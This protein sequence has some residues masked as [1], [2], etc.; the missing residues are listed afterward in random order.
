MATDFWANYRKWN[1]LISERYLR[2]EFANRPVYLDVDDTDLSKIREAQGWEPGDDQADFVA[3]VANTLKTSLR[4]HGDLLEI[5]MLRAKR[6]QGMAAEE[7]PPFVAVL[8][9]FSY[10][11]FRM[12]TTEEAASHNYYTPL[13]EMIFGEDWTEEQR[14]SVHK[15]YV[16]SGPTIWREFARWLEYT[17]HGSHGNP[18][19]ES[20]DRR[21]NIKYPLS[22]AILR[23]S[24]RE[25]LKDCFAYARLRPGERLSGPDMEQVLARW[26]P[27][28]SLSSITKK[29]WAKGGQHRA[30]MAQIAVEE[31]ITWDGMS[32][33][34]TS[35]GR[36]TGNLI[37]L[38]NKVETPYPSIDCSFG[39][40]GRDWSRIERFE[41][42]EGS[43]K[44]YQESIAQPIDELTLQRTEPGL[45]E[46]MQDLSIADLFGSLIRL[47]N[48][49]TGDLIRWIPRKFMVLEYDDELRKWVDTSSTTIDKAMM[50][51]T[52]QSREEKLCSILAPSVSRAPRRWDRGN[53][54]GLPAGWVLLSDVWLGS[55]IRINDKEFIALNS[56]TMSARI[57]LNG[58]LKIPGEKIWL[59]SRLPSV[60]LA[61]H[62]GI[63]QTS[64]SKAVAGAFELRLE[65]SSPSGDFSTVTLDP[66]GDPES[67]SFK[68]TDLELPNGHYR[69]TIKHQPEGGARKDLASAHIGVCSADL[70]RSERF[71]AQ[72]AQVKSEDAWYPTQDLVTR[73]GTELGNSPI[74]DPGTLSLPP[75]DLQ[76][77]STDREEDYLPS[78]GTEQL[79]ATQDCAHYTV[80]PPKE[81][82][83]NQWVYGNCKYCGAPV[84][85]APFRWGS[86]EGDTTLGS[87]K[88][89]KLELIRPV[90]SDFPTAT[91]SSADV[92][93]D[94]LLEACCY[95][96][97]GTS[98]EFLNL[99]GQSSE[100]T[101]FAPEA[102]R[103][104]YSLGH[105]ELWSDGPEEP[106]RWRVTP[107]S[108]VV[109][110]QE[111][112]YLT[113]YRSDN[114][115]R[116]VEAQVR[117]F[118]GSLLISEQP[119]GPA[120]ISIEGLD[121]KELDLITSRLPEALGEAVKLKLAPHLSPEISI[122]D[123]AA[124]IELLP[125]SSPPNTSH[126]F[127]SANL[128]WKEAID[129][130]Q[131]GLYRLPTRPVQHRINL[132]GRWRVTPYQLGKH[133]AGQINGVSL[134][135]YDVESET[136]S[137]SK[138][139]Q[140]P[141]PYDKIATMCTGRLPKFDLGSKSYRYEGVPPWTASSIW[142]GLYG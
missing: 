99:Y 110:A 52:H 41:V 107:P 61:A 14:A 53:M 134:M 108:I 115:I 83:T 122:P 1:E 49:D 34:A 56:K 70:P 106:R 78:H 45:W 111:K 114:F 57:D 141:C 109:S 74:N 48:K 97:T 38:L 35:D 32:E 98:A 67:V 80:L 47:E 64:D 17:M 89:A 72:D 123:R 28:S 12:T 102:I 117:T 62:A 33:D 100:G 5:H 76:G 119:D 26:V 93:Y 42:V 121:L 131:P 104:L 66:M 128:T 50:I 58:G 94:A 51:L 10:A 19:A 96:T 23:T 85:G 24:D 116:E 120:F 84:G 73:N 129:P 63:E 124:L 139:S 59:R 13:T 69:L 3:V 20:L 7:P 75:T 36:R 55:A 54:R 22:Q 137:C 31:L 112:A 82:G 43:A 81:K 105:L 25:N 133:L 140:L 16:K 101:G 138:G 15:G 68:L 87:D 127:D 103:N 136:I 29:I 77:T 40:R 27:G 11:A 9:F 118:G 18:T 142:E 4:L 21:V 65:E 37:L 130:E 135:A 125:E 126:I 86:N 30:A 79:G 71:A 92:D 132:S 39:M 6:R 60:S 88:S 8:A 95:L 46:V 90:V 44:P 113:G 2:P 91:P